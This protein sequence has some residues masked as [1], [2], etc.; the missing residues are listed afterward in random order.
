MMNIDCKRFFVDEGER[1]RLK[2]WPTLVKPFY[3]SKEH[4]RDIL[5]GG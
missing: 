1:V 2:D 5:D 4:Y 3:K